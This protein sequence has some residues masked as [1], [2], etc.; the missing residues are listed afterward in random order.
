MT[1]T[2]NEAE[3]LEAEAA[4][5]DGRCETCTQPIKIYRYP[6]NKTAAIFMQAMAAAV[7]V[8]GINDVDISTLGLGYSVRSQVTKI[9]QHGLVARVKDEN[10]AQLPSRWL[11]TNKGWDF[12]NG[13]PIWSRV[14]VFNNQVLGH[15]DN[16]VT[17]HGILGEKVD[18]NDPIFTA[19]AVSSSEAH[20]YGNLRQPKRHMQVTAIWRGHIGIVLEPGKLYDLE[21]DRLSLGQPI[22]V[23]VAGIGMNYKDIAAFQKDWKTT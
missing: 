6:V 1:M 18:P 13:K 11:V 10:G 21:I 9:R 14:I 20:T 5:T 7:K 23:K 17:I 19:T 3:L 22:A 8:T 2:I 12:V 16:L 15:D 4:E